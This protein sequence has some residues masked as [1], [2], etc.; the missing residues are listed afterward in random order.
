MPAPGAPVTPTTCAR[1]AGR[2]IAAAKARAR[3]WAASMRVIRR[4]M[5]LKSRAS[6]LDSSSSSVYFI[7]WMLLLVTLLRQLDNFV[8]ELVNGCNNT[9][10]CLES[11]LKGDNPYEFRGDIHRR[12][13][14]R[15]GLER[16]KVTAFCLTINGL[17]R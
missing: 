5:A 1:P 14:Y 15:T 8:Q 2:R 16:P 12:E 3:G 7:P 10:A 13:L 6:V 17:T 4:A 11:S 9:G